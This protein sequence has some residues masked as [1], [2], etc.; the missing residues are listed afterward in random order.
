[1]I[2]RL[3]KDLGM[4]PSQI[5]KQATTYDIMVMDV[6]NTFENY[7]QQKANGKVDPSVFQYTQDELKAMMEKSRGQ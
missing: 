2:G 6:L 4:L 1:M 7:Q 3:S 5:E